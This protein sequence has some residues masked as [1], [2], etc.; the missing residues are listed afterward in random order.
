[1]RRI[2]PN[3][4]INAAEYGQRYRRSTE[5][6]TYYPV[7]RMQWCPSCRKNRT[8]KQFTEG[9]KFCNDCRRKI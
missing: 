6:M 7:P 3:S 9:K 1:M 4:L 2:D 8:W 5:N